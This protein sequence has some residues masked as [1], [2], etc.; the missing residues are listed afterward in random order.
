MIRYELPT[1]WIN[2]DSSSIQK[3]FVEAKSSI[4]ALRML[5]YH[6]PNGDVVGFR[7][8]L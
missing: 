5:P 6:P 2:Y 7:H 3:E 4:K 8:R 1:S